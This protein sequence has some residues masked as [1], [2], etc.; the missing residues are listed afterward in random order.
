M[1]EVSVY[2]KLQAVYFPIRPVC[3]FISE[4]TSKKVMNDVRRES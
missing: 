4:K 3:D 1:I 2:G